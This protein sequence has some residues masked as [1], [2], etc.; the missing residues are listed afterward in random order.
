MYVTMTAYGEELVAQEL[1]AVGDRGVDMTPL[2]PAVIARL[3]EIEREQFASEGARA[4]NRWEPNAQATQWRKFQAGESLELMKA[5]EAL[6]DALT[7]SSGPGAVRL[8]TPYSLEF[9]ASDLVQFRVHQGNDG[10][11][12]YPVRT[13]ID[14]TS[15]DVLDFAMVMAEYVVGTRNAVGAPI[16]PASKKFSTGRNPLR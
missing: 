10:A 12:T 1:F 14:L 15:H 4:G 6:Y 13:P 9:G 5:T 2:W 3:E 16:N 7:T 8:P 11:Q